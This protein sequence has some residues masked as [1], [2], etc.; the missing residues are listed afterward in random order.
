MKFLMQIYFSHFLVA[1]ILTASTLNGQVTKIMGKVTDASSG[2]PI[3]FA[4]IYFKGTTIGVTS[5]FDGLFSIESKLA[6]DTL[7][8]SVMGY[9]SQS[10]KVIRNRFQ[11]IDFRLE[12]QNIDLAEVVIVAGENPAEIILRKI[13]ERKEVNRYK[14]YEALQYEVYNK[15]AI[16]ANN[17]SE[18]FQQRR[19]FR[20]FQF[21]FDYV[22]TST[23]SGKTYLPIF[24]SETLSDVYI[25]KSPSA[26][27]EVIRA[28]KVSGIEN[29]SVLQ[30]LGT[31]FQQY[32]FYENYLTLF[33]R[34]FVS[35]IANFGLNYYKYYLVDSTFI[36][37]QWCYKIM[38]K[39][40]RKQELTFTGNFWVHDTTF[41]IKSFDLRIAD[42]ANINYINDLVL[43]QEFELVDGKHWMVV[44]DVG[45]GDFNVLRDNKS[46]LGFFGKK[47][48]SYRNFVFDQPMDKKFYSQ[49]TN[50]IVN[51]GAYKMKDEFWHQNRHDS[52]SK[53]EKTV[54]FLVDSLQNL[55]AFQ[56]WI[57]IVETVVTGYYKTNFI[58]WGP[59]AS[60]LSFNSIEGTRF[61]MGGRTTARFNER[62]RLEGHLAYGTKDAQFKYGGGFL[63]LPNK[64]PRR[65]F[66]G[67][68]KYDLEQLGNSPNAFREDFF[69]AALFRRNPADKLSMTKELLFH[70]EHEWFNGLSNKLTFL[71]KEIIPLQKEA[72]TLR[73]E[74]NEIEYKD[75]IGVFE[76]GLG[77]RFAFSEKFLIGDFDRISVG[78]K[79]PVF[80][81]Q[82]A[83]GMQ[84]VFSGKY[85][86]HKMKVNIRQWFNVMNIGWSKY[87]IES[88]RIWGKLP[89]P[90]LELHSGNETFLFDEYSFNLMNYFE[91]ISDRYVSLYY[92]HHFD[93]YFLNRIPLMRKLKWR[94][95]GF[96]NGV[97]GSMSPE[98]EWYNLFP[99]KSHSLEKPYFEAG[100]GIENIFKIIRVDGIWRL[101][102][103]EN[104]DIKRF[105]IF[106]SLYFAF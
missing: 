52:L 9:L 56:T 17:I 10:R 66:G 54:Y 15:I 51:E 61:R 35:P 86:Y 101:S 67:N 64:N 3:P 45:I 105:A 38:F 8:A 91:F 39:P 106:I 94:E 48:T 27:K 40:R 19:L 55:P 28:G 100:V 69:F 58:E 80:G 18:Q 83:Y 53:D 96:F 41:A 2:E 47:T 103:L 63:Y 85:E 89:Y 34:N 1:F 42:D 44:K 92:T 77:L 6:T 26:Q 30:F 71:N 49:P 104:D 82:Y 99:E 46:L 20:P 97:I 65:A 4:N 22:D 87:I 12:S 95:V 102:H 62:L 76:V 33:Q 74:F 70:Y 98:N 14:D 25:R 31:M 37:D 60:F 13:I 50:V 79:Y 88:G 32:D 29:E 73:N 43:N 78:T 93:G 68:Y 5:D 24:L 36:G 21:I 81:F 84:G 90:L 7:T 59:Y 16:D 23:I 72:I 57:D 75:Q 11:E